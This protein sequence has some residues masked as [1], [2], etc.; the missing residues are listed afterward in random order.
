MNKLHKLGRFLVVSTSVVLAVVILS[1]CESAEEKEL[2]LDREHEI[3]MQRE[4]NGSAEAS[5]ERS[6]E[7]SLAYIQRP[8]APGS[9]IDYRGNSSYGYWNNGG[10]VW[11]NPQSQ[12]AISSGHYVDYGMATGVLTTAVLSQALFNSNNSNGWQSTNVTVNNYT[13]TG[14]KTISK[15]KYTKRNKRLTKKKK[16]QAKKRKLTKTKSSKTVN[17]STGTKKVNKWESKRKAKP[18]YA[19]GGFQNKFAKNQKKS[20]YAKNNK[21]SSKSK[22]KAPA[23]S[24]YKKS[25]PKSKSKRTK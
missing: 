16:A 5:R 14:G 17:K 4:M 7:R 25:K 10:W 19:K 8:I 15:E 18:T 21:S 12:Y 11:N 2:R 1:G 22:Y 3:R 24:T 6:H 9:Y 23:K 13:S 20:T